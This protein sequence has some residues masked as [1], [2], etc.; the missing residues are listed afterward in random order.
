MDFLVNYVEATTTEKELIS[1]SFNDIKGDSS[2]TMHYISGL[3]WYNERNFL[4]QYDCL[5]LFEPQDW[6]FPFDS[7]RVKMN[8]DPQFT[9]IGFLERIKRNVNIMIFQE[10]TFVTIINDRSSPF[11]KRDSQFRLLFQSIFEPKMAIGGT[12]YLHMLIK[13]GKKRQ[14]EEKIEQ[15]EDADDVYSQPRRVSHLKFQR[16]KSADMLSSCRRLRLLSGPHYASFHHIAG[17]RIL[18]LGERHTHARCATGDRDNQEV[19]RWLAEMAAFA[20]ECL[21]I[22]VEITMWPG[23]KDFLGLPKTESFGSKP[24]ST[25]SIE[26]FAKISEKFPQHDMTGLSAIK[27]TFEPCQ[28][29]SRLNCFKNVVRF[30][31]IDLREI[32]WNAPSS[33]L[34][35]ARSLRKQCLR[36]MHLR[37]MR[38]PQNAKNMKPVSYERKNF[39]GNGQPEEEIRRMQR[40]AFKFVGGDESSMQGYI[41]VVRDVIRQIRSEHP[42]ISEVELSADEHANH[43]LEMVIPRITKARRKVGNE[44]ADKIW[45]ALYQTHMAGDAEF[46]DFGLN[47]VDAFTVDYYSL[48]RIF[49]RFD[50]NKMRR[51]PSGC[52]KDRYALVANVIWYGGAAHAKAMTLTLNRLGYPP[53]FNIGKDFD[54]GNAMQNAQLNSWL[55]FQ[56]PFD[57]WTD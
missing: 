19:H 14:R 2:I 42:Y 1:K 38:D 7:H 43:I 41:D 28:N 3:E 31:N 50:R 47:H 11:K 9:M 16:E 22:M 44:F 4:S 39:I 33:S 23:N 57:F 56:F 46:A 48:L 8:D 18:L 25:T 51:G 20:P 45:E 13:T 35:N 53:T 37:M 34:K 12:Y 49:T 52:W 29:A 6:K 36:S 30:H 55:S 54:F 24:I 21:D 32:F 15:R 10:R 40:E 17:R 27:I 26:S 5:L